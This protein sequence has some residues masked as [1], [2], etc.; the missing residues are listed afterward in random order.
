MMFNCII[1]FFMTGGVYSIFNEYNMNNIINLINYFIIASYY[2]SFLILMHRV[3]KQKNIKN[4]IKNSALI[5]ILISICLISSIWSVNINTTI[6]STLYLL[7]T[8]IYGIYLFISY[9]NQ[10]LIIIL[11]RVLI[12][13]ASISFIF[14]ILKPEYA[15]QYDQRFLAWR[16]LYAH[17]NTL[18]RLMSLGALCSY[19]YIKLYKNMN[20][21]KGTIFF[22]IFIMILLFTNSTT[23]LIT[24]FLS[25]GLIF[26]LKFSKKINKKINIS[27]RILFLII[28]LFILLNNQYLMNVIIIKV[29]NRDATLTGRTSIWSLSIELIKQK[30]LSGYG[31]NAFWTTE[32][33]PQLLY[34]R[35]V[36]NWNVVS[37]HNGFL[38]IILGIGLPGFLLYLFIILKNIVIRLK[39]LKY[40]N[41]LELFPI[42]FLFFILI[43]NISETITM[44]PNSIF[45]VIQVVYFVGININRSDTLKRFL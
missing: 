13:C 23:S 4:V 43:N 41:V 7:G 27:V 14:V 3:R 10:E 17:K 37:S 39:K 45:W 15:I 22:A 35:S 8:T 21:V 11:M 31:Y 44:Q 28:F 34:I 5:F 33:N 29:F 26:Y 2:L 1:L 18:A 16:G 12:L 19:F 40:D 36:L 9:N 24:L 30:I 6:K 32:D 38:D 42:I 20:K 25:F